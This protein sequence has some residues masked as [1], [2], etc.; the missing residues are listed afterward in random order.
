MPNCIGRL[1]TNWSAVFERRGEDFN[2]R[3]TGNDI[4]YRSKIH[5]RTFCTDKSKE[6]QNT[7]WLLP[8]LRQYQTLLMNKKKIV[9]HNF[10][11]VTV[12]VK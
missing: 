3:K 11:S 4:L 5:L 1:H 9:L 8:V 6:A 12:D 7:S 2:I 10:L